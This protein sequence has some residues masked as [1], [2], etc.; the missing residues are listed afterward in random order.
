MPNTCGNATACDSVQNVVAVPW[1]AQAISQSV[2]V[3]EPVLF[4]TQGHRGCG[5]LAMRLYGGGNILGST[6]AH[7]IRNECETANGFQE[8]NPE[9]YKMVSWPAQSVD[10][11][12][13]L[14]MIGQ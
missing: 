13:V 8:P 14:L 10:W 6:G 4:S 5:Y 3:T 1:L 12:T 11:N 7:R 9:K 2:F